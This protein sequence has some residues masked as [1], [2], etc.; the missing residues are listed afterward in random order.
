MYMVGLDVDKDISLVSTLQVTTKNE[1]VLYAGNFKRIDTFFISYILIQ[2]L[3]K[4]IKL[5]KI[6]QSAGNI[7]SS[8]NV[9]IQQ[10]ASVDADS[11]ISD[12]Y[13]P[14][15]K[16]DQDKEFGY[17][18]AGLIE[19]DGH[20]SE[21]KLEIVQH[22]KD[23]SLA[24][25]LKTRI[26]FG[27]ISKVKNKKAIKFVISNQKGR[28]KVQELCNGKFIANFKINQQLKYKRLWVGDIKK[29]QTNINQSTPWL[30]GFQDAHGS[31][32]IFIAKSPTHKLKKS[33]RQEIKISQKEEF[34]LKQL[35]LFIN[36]SLYKDKNGIFRFKI[37]GK[38]KIKTMIDYL[39]LFPL[40][41]IKYTQYH[42]QRKTFRVMQRKEHLTINGLNIVS[43][44]KQ[45]LN[46]IYK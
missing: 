16:F 1:I 41:S 21:R 20:F 42:I 5:S 14:H 43:K 10:N 11:H 27:Q 45:K 23:I 40:Q 37:T 32:G 18:L 19:G 38:H 13:G 44:N 35:K 22:E 46:K 4:V 2:C 24:H 34:I 9:I 12:H 29:P 17:Y 36:G 30:S 26:G 31:Q 3:K 8:N 6:K 7:Y 33:V 25:I 15:R 39:D 28:N